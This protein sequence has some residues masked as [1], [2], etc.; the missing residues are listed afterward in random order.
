MVNIAWTVG[1]R[2][3]VAGALPRRHPKGNERVMAHTERTAR[4]ARTVRAGQ[5]FRARKR[6]GHVWEVD[7]VVADIEGLPHAKLRA[8]DDRHER[9]TASCSV[10]L[11]RREYEDLGG[12][13]EVQRSWS[14]GGL[15]AGAA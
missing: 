6:W 2:G 7:A 14:G 4:A 8:I 9:R 5:R 10:L 11:D 12:P 15:D 1:A 13:G 3:R